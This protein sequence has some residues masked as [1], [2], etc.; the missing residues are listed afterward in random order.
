MKKVKETKEEQTPIDVSTLITPVLN[1]VCI[2]LIT[3][4]DYADGK[5]TKLNK[6]CEIYAKVVSVGSTVQSMK[7]NDYVLLRS[8]MTFPACFN[9]FGKEYTIVNESDL[10]CVIDASI[11]INFS[12]EKLKEG[13]KS[14]I[15]TELN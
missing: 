2:Q 14:G 9:L 12:S 1:R 3:E 15:I 5:I 11:T 6:G 8:G 10:L 4:G 13:N 7:A